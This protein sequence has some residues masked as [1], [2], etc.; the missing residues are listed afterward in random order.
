MKLKHLLLAAALVVATTSAAGG[1]WSTNTAGWKG[2]VSAP[3]YPVASSWADSLEN[4]P[5]TIGTLPFVKVNSHA[6]LLINVPTGTTSLD[7]WLAN[8]LI[9]GVFGFDGS[10]GVYVDG[11]YTTN[12]NAV[13]ATQVIQRYT[14]ALDGAPHQVAIWSGYQST[15]LGTYVYA[16]QGAGISLATPPTVTRKTTVYGDSIAEGGASTPNPQFCYFAILR[17]IHPGSISQEAWG[18]RSLWDDSEPAL[19]GIPSTGQQGFATQALLAQ[20]LVGLVAGAA[21]RDVVLTIGY[22]DLNAG[23]WASAAAFGSAYANLLDTI[24]A[25]DAGAHVYAVS[26]IT[27]SI[28]LSTYRA[29]IASDCTARSGYCTYQDGLQIMAASGLSGDNTHPNN[30]GHQ[31]MALGTGPSAGSTSLRAM[32]GI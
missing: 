9:T 28:D 29:V 19:G 20:R 12:W 25:A 6:R 2:A 18:S 16:V 23:H 22:N 32:L 1:E 17:A 11:V 26:M 27:A 13:G 4:T 8:T 31:A 3:I 21:T 24:H 14:L 15:L 30:N 7:A 5:Q 10:V